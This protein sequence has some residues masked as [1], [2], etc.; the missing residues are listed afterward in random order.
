MA[1]ITPKDQ[2]VV[3]NP[4]FVHLDSSKKTDSFSIVESTASYMNASTDESGKIVGGA[5][6]KSRIIL[7]K[8]STRV[9]TTIQMQP[10]A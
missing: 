10:M 2:D 5:A 8:E 7:E 6:K 1:I 4:V 9:K 3:Y